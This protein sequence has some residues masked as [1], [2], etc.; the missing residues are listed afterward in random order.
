MIIFSA[1]DK[2]IPDLPRDNPLD[3]NGSPNPND[4]KLIFS[5]YEVVCKYD[6]GAI[7]YSEE[8]TVK[9][10][11]RI[12]LQI[13]VKNTGGANLSGVRATITTSSSL[14]QVTTLPSG[15]YV[16]L[17]EGS[18]TNDYINASSIGFATITDG[19]NYMS[20]PNYNAYAIEF[21]VSSIAVAGNQ[22]PF[23]LNMTDNSGGSW[24]ETFNVIV[25]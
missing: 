4:K 15:E 16:K 10:G 24:S 6:S 3:N 1:C 14:A 12:F 2:I 13:T 19:Q 9:H 11:D 22:I 8:K 7:T 23:I 21:K 5:S 20:A 18:E 17:T 25:N